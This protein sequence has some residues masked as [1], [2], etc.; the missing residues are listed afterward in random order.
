M[1]IMNA[2]PNKLAFRNMAE[3]PNYLSTVEDR[4]AAA[5]RRGQGF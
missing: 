4:M 1:P 2:T 5:A 3:L